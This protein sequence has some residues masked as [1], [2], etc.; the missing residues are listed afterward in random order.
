MSKC[1]RDTAR[2]K[3]KRAF[4]PAIEISQPKP[5]RHGLALRDA[6]L[7]KEAEH[8]LQL[9]EPAQALD[10][11]KALPA[12]AEKNRWTMKVYV[13]AVHAAKGQGILG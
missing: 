10:H 12:S 9:G 5:D 3:R 8:W 4:M 7:V 2:M 6:L 13:A 11:L 1:P